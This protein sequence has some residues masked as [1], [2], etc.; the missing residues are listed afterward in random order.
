[1]TRSLWNEEARRIESASS[2]VS[3]IDLHDARVGFERAEGDLAL[4]GE[5]E[6][7]SRRRGADADASLRG[8]LA[9]IALMTSMERAAWPKPCPET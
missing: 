5:I 3:A 4:D 8:V 9:R 2:S 1:V 6:E 7:P